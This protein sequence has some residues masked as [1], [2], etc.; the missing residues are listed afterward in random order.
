MFTPSNADIIEA[1]STRWGQNPTK[2]DNDNVRK[3]IDNFIKEKIENGQIHIRADII[4][5]LQEVSLQIKRE[6]K[7]D[8]SINNPNC[9]IKLRLKEDV[10]KHQ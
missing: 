6:G 10:Y 9:D 1:R 7:D 8:I 5:T 4:S 3:M 2:N